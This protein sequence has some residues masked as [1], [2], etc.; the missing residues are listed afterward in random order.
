MAYSFKNRPSTFQTLSGIFLDKFK[1]FCIKDFL[2]DICEKATHKQHSYSFENIERRKICFNLFIVMYGGQ[3]IQ[4]I[5]M[6]L[7]GFFFL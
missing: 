2:C 7:S 4:Q 5:S 3:H 1:R 6:I